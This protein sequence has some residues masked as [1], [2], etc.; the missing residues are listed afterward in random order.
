MSLKLGRKEALVGG[1]HHYVHES[2]TLLTF[3]SDHVRPLHK[4]GQVNINN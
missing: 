3:I 4:L 2:L 1:V